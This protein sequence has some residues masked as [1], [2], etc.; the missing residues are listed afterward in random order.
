M[1]QQLAKIVLCLKIRRLGPEG[2]GD[3]VPLKHR[4]FGE[5]DVADQRLQPRAAGGP[6]RV[7]RLHGERI[8]PAIAEQT[9]PA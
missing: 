5:G 4:L 1:V 9:E 2:F 3:R 6:R 7:V 8:R